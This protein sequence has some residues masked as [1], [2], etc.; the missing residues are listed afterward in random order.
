MLSDLLNDITDF[1]KGPS[2][3]DDA[4][5]RT[6]H[7]RTIKRSDFTEG[8]HTYGIEWSK[9]YLYT[10]ID[11]PLQQVL[12]VD[13]KRLSSMWNYG[14]FQGRLENGSSLTNPWFM[15][16]NSNAPFDQK[17]YLILNVAVGSRNGWFP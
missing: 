10:W 9:D 7:A 14:Q 8:F 11:N 6:T 5:W 3:Q 4:F 15:S 12:Y 2:V 17:F 16:E 13:F 1:W